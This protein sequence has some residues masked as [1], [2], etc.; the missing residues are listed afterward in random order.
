MNDKLL[1]IENLRVNFHLPEGIARAVDGI[2]FDL[3]AGETLGLV[4][5]SG[6]GK[7]VTALSILGLVPSPPGQIGAGR[8]RFEDR[9]LLRLDAEQLRR[10]RGRE[11][12][13]I[14][15]EPMTSLNP[16]LPIGRQVA[17]PLMIHKAFSKSDALAEAAVWLDHVKIPAARK[18]LDD[19]GCDHP[20]PDP[21][22]HAGTEIG[23]EYVAIADYPRSWSCGS[24]GVAGGGDVCRA[25]R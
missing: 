19:Y 8:I 14:F 25:D 6:C 24:D 11:I 23:A 7:S 17:E 20:G 3:A 2:S 5:E 21:V 13:M 9:N 1:D 18:R 22:S 15:Q 4:G 12:S 16:V 10:I